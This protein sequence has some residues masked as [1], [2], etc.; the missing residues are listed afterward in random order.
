MKLLF[1][2]KTLKQVKGGAERV[3]AELVSEMAKRGHYVTICT[4]DSTDGE[5]LYPIDSRVNQIYIGGGQAGRR[6]GVVDFIKRLP[7]LRK[8]VLEAKPD[9]VIGFTHAMYVPLSVAMIGIRIPLLASEHIVP[10]YYEHRKL[11]FF[12]LRV[13]SYLVDKFSV[14]SAQIGVLYPAS[15]RSKLVVLPNAV[16]PARKFANAEA[17]GVKIKVVLNVGRLVDF[18]DQ[19]TLIDAFALLAEKY[20]DWNLRIIGEGELRDSLEK[21]IVSYGLKNRIFLPG[22][23]DKIE[24]EYESAQIFV[25]SSIYEGFGLVTAEASSHC[26]PCVGFRD[27]PGTNELIKHGVTGILVDPEDRIINLASAIEQLICDGRMRKEMGDLG[28][29]RMLRYTPDRVFTLWEET[30]LDL[31]IR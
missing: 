8:T 3:F 9:A 26:L 12:L 7:N 13:S 28:R 15:V 31:S 21:K 16:V 4:F 25:V 14:L 10:A 11:E 17:K 24:V 1:A 18:K 29:E 20:P 5:S 23:S 22:N 30:L 2:I 19:K 27:C 6:T